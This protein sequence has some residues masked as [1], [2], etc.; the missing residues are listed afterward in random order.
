MT[1]PTAYTLPGTIPPPANAPFSLNLGVLSWDPVN[2]YQPP[3]VYNWNLAI[4]R[5]L[6][7]NVLARAAYVGSQGR[8]LKE[9]LNLNPSPVGG[10]LLRLNTI[11][12]LAAFSTVQQDAQDINS[13]YNSLQLS[14]H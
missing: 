8:H 9:T 5:Q 13:S 2:K 4:E 12:G 1:Q 6:P 11:T 7:A 3:T 10:G 14:A